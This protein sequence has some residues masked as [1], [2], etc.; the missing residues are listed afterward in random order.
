MSSSTV[1]STSPILNLTLVTISSVLLLIWPISNTIALR[2]GLLIVGCI[3]ALFLFQRFSKTSSLFALCR[4]LPISLGLGM[5]FWVLLHWLV[6]SQD[7][8]LQLHELVSTWKR[9]LLAFLIGGATGLVLRK[10]PNQANFLWLGI[11]ASFLF[12]LGDYLIAAMQTGQIFMPRYYF[13][14]PFGNKINTVIMGI[15]FISAVCGSAAF[16][17][18]Q[19]SLDKMKL[20]WGLSAFWLSGVLLILFSYTT[21]ID[22]RNGI[23]IATILLSVWIM[24]ILLAKL[25]SVKNRLSTNFNAS[26]WKSL[27]VI[28]LPLLVL[29][30]FIQG[31]LQINRGWN[32]FFEDLHIATQIDRYP[33]WQNTPQLGYPKTASGETVYPNNYE[34]AAWA[35]AGI[36]SI[37]KNPL[38]FGLLEHS[39][40][41]VIKQSYPNATIKSSHSAWIDYGLAF[42]IPGLILTLGALLSIIGI[43]LRQMRASTSPAALLAIWV[44][45]GLLLTFTVAEVSSKHSIEILFFCI[46]LLSAMIFP[47]TDSA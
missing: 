31:H 47:A 18:R 5:F 23:G 27:L 12:L 34:R 43:A 46:A 15:I 24:I 19:I 17:Y 22:T 29:L 39:L 40:E 3:L 4:F 14:S 35:T 16:Q 26:Y 8:A 41:R 42:G 28:A 7:P 38:G 9:T 13:V 36:D 6:F 2:N 11:Y 32:H 21:I 33:Q 1:N 25:R 30:F 45:C 20:N 10:R 37:T 44:A